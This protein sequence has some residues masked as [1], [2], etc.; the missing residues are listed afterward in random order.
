MKI[1][2]IARAL[3]AGVLILTA[4]ACSEKKPDVPLETASQSAAVTYDL[5]QAVNAFNEQTITAEYSDVETIYASASTHLF[6]S[7]SAG[8]K[9]QQSSAETPRATERTTVKPTVSSTAAPTKETVRVTV[10]EGETL[11]QIFKKLEEKGVASFDELMTTAQT[12]DYSYYP[13]VAKIPSNSNRCF[14]LEGYLFPDTYEFYTNQKPQDAI[15]KFLRNGKAK[16]T[17]SMLQKASSLG[18]SFDEVLTVASIIEKEGAKSSEV[19][20]IAAVI[21]NRLEAGMKLQMDS[22]IYYIERNVKPYLTGDINRYNGYYNTYKCAT[23]PAGPISNPGLKTIN[24]AL[25]PADVPYLYFCHDENAN[26]YYA[27]T[28]EEHQENL[29]LAGI[30]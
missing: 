5:S 25:N 17:D 21:Y 3:S 15:G 27:E 10:S 1:I 14:R 6:P 4:A 20:K 26:Y 24:A 19:A 28:Y 23:L 2:R 8:N 22:T 13:L 30:E 29:K 11:T 7:V 18:Y 16:I 9:E 12:Y